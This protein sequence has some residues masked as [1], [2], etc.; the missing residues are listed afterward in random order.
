MNTSSPPTPSEP[1]DFRLEVTK[2]IVKM[3]EEGTAPWQKPWEGGRMLMP[4]NQT[5]GKPYRGGNALYLMITALEK[6]YIDPRWMT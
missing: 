3:L 4:V 1:R 5:T 2:R 6:G